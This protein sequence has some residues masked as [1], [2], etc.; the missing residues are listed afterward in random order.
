MNTMSSNSVC[1][2]NFDESLCQNTSFELT[3]VDWYDG[4]SSCVVQC[5]KCDSCYRGFLIDWNADH[6]E[7]VFSLSPFPM[8]SMSTI[9][10]LVNK[11][12]QSDIRNLDFSQAESEALDSFA[13]PVYVIGFDNR[14]N[15][16]VAA[17]RIAQKDIE[18]AKEW[19]IESESTVASVNWHKRLFP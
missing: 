16:F 15:E 5:K 19:L 11:R 1:C 9:A 8:E 17:L 13:E 18:F 12:H 2:K 14:T 10:D 6:S 4:P 3:I 7:R